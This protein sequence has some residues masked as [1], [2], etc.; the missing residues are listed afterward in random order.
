MYCSGISI[1]NFKQ[2]NT[3]YIVF[4]ELQLSQKAK[5]KNLDKV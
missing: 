5:Y 2:V 1:V 4:R 3:G